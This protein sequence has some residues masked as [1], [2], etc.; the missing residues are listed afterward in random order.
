MRARHL[1]ST[2][3][4]WFV[5]AFLI[6]LPLTTSSQ[7]APRIYREHVE[8]HWFVPNTKFWYRI[9]TGKDSFEFVIVD[10]EHGTRLPAFDHS[11]VAAG[12]SKLLGHAV[13]ASNLPADQLSFESRPGTCI[14]I[15]QGSSWQLDLSTYAIGPAP[16]S[17]Q[18][19]RTLPASDQ[20]RPSRKSGR[21]TSIRFDNRLAEPIEV[22]W[23]DEEG[24]RQHYATVK[25][26]EQWE[27]HTYAGH[28]WLA[29]DTKDRPLAVFQ[30]TRGPGTAVVDGKPPTTKPSSP[31]ALAPSAPPSGPQ[32]PDGKW[33]V[34]LKEDN[35]FLH[36][37]AGGKELAL[38]EDGKPGDA[39]SLD[40]L[41]WSPDSQKLVAMRVEPG[42]EHKMYTVESSPPDQLQPRLRTLD[43]RKPGDRIEHPRPQLFHVKS[44]QHIAVKDDLFA[45]PWSIEDLRWSADSSRFTFLYNQRGHQALRVIAVDAETGAAK[46][47]IDEHSDTFIDYSGKYFC[48]W[49]GERELIWMSERDGWNHLW[50]YDAITGRVKNQITKGEWVVQQVLHVD[51]EA[52]QIWF[53]AGGVWPGQDPYYSH[54]CR[55]NFDGSGF[56]RL[57]EGD[58]NHKPRWSPGDK[59]FID[60]WS[61]VDLAPVAEL[62][63]SDTGKLVCKLEEAD[64]GEV[65]A[66]RG[67]HWPQR[68]SA[69]GRDGTTDIYGIILLPHDFDAG[70]TYPVLEEIYAGP[71]DFYTPK[72]FR[73]MYK[74]MQSF[75]DKGM[76]VVQCD[77][78]GTSGRS[79]KFHDVC[80][81]NLR[82][83]GFPDRIA[84]MK[85]AAATHPQMDLSRVG[86]FGGSAGGQSAMGA[87]LW[88]N[89]FYTV[90]VA[91]CGCHDNRMDKIW[92]N[93]QWMGWPIDKSYED[94]SN[95][96][97]A[98]LLQGK[99]MLVVGELDDNVDP[100]STMQ[101]VNAL[102]KA[103]KDFELVIVTGAHHGSAETPYGSRRRME[104]LTRN[105]LGGG[106]DSG[107]N[108]PESLGM[109]GHNNP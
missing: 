56:T 98:H 8:P 22:Y 31:P 2:G 79:K 40:S 107:A 28:V 15:G 68:F 32:S 92:W 44:R 106:L 88:H 14:L 95:A 76:I 13:S 62:R 90:A 51:E 19:P 67:G 4:Q 81:K 93:E 53:M 1:L 10:A 66:E 89:D 11:R 9:E 26:G 100:S 72:S 57:T 21:D 94:N 77:G 50:L 7:A 71:Q 78:M 108:R 64:A 37:N 84:W 86:I 17:Q 47:T 96:V 23:I 80:W 49:I 12:L 5:T 33:L 55:V 85:A 43:Y 18:F 103:D 52:R 42:Q 73:A 6:V 54:L 36:E 65:L 59:F 20:V 30:A 46:P 104:F 25:P 99:L 75:A 82:D 102:E 16:A 58:G 41:R 83:A 24:H 97:N 39:Y 29:T 61:R 63:R 91:D 101:V 74:T 27:H 34:L 87:L 3:S 38:S 70:K 48:K 35:L 45:N 69:K 60:S 109:P 105:L